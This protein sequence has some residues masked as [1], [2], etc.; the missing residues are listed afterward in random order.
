VCTRAA[1][2][3]SSS[4]AA[5]DGLGSVSCVPAHSLV[6]WIRGK[7]GLSPCPHTKQ[8]SLMARLPYQLGGSE[9]SQKKQ[10]KK[11]SGFSLQANYT[12]QATAACRRS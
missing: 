6:L 3:I 12:D 1:P 2:E 7:S 4:T 8:V 10:N 5:G 11:L 9:G